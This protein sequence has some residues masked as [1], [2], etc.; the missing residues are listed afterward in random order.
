MILMIQVLS[1]FVL[2]TNGF[3]HMSLES[4]HFWVWSSMVPSSIRLAFVGRVFLLLRFFP[5]AILW[6]AWKERNIRIFRGESSSI[7]DLLLVVILGVVIGNSLIILVLMIL[8]L[9]GRLV[10][11]VGCPRRR[12]W[13]LG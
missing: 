9:T 6:S 10:C 11:F 5:F 3:F 7:E 12:G 2:N 8:F 4:L 1:L 13:L